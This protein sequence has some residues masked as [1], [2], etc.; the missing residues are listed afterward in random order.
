MGYPHPP[1]ANFKKVCYNGRTAMRLPKEKEVEI[2]KALASK[3]TGQVGLDFGLDKTFSTMNSVR[4][5]VTAIKNRISANPAEYGVSQEVV[6]LVNKAMKNRNVDKRVDVPL[7]VKQKE[8]QGITNVIESVKNGAWALIDKKIK[9][10]AKSTKLL[11]ETT[12]QQLGT[13][14]GIAFDKHQ[15]IKGEATENI[16]VRAKIDKNLSPEELLNVVLAQRQE[17]NDSNNK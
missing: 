3:S 15:I 1:L 14:A 13:I 17:N 16:A 6:D 11:K 2:F 8:A 5:A 7:A 10:T 4:N 12:F 9:M